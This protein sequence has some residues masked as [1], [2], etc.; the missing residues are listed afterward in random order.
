M[1]R[2]LWKKQCRGVRQ[3][4]PLSPKVFTTATRT[5]SKKILQH[6]FVKKTNKQTKNEKKLHHYWLGWFTKNEIGIFQRDTPP[7]HFVHYGNKIIP[8]KYEKNWKKFRGCY[9]A[10]N[11]CT[12]S[13]W[14]LWA[15]FFTTQKSHVNFSRLFQKLVIIVWLMPKK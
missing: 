5:T 15:I 1:S 2:L 14:D 7:P 8:A 11:F 13:Q 12:Q 6:L 9:R 3:G 4:Y 10:M